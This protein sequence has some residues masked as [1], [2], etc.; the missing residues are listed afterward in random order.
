[1][2]NIETTLIYSVKPGASERTLYDAAVITAIVLLLFGSL[3]LLLPSAAEAQRQATRSLIINP[4]LDELHHQATGEIRGFNTFGGWAGF[5]HFGYSSDNHHLWYQDLGGYVE[6]WRQGNS[7]SLLL[8][9]Q[10]Q[11]IADP[12]NDI[13]F[14]PR[15]I[16]WEEGLLY[17]ARMDPGYLQVGF[18]HRCKH[19]IDNLDRGE[20]R[21]LIFSSFTV[22]YQQPLSVFRDNDL[23]LM[24]AYDN[25]LITWDRRIPRDLEVRT[26]DWNDLQ[27]EFTLQGHWRGDPLGSGPSVD[28]R[29][30]IISLDSRLHINHGASAG[31]HVH[32]SGG[33]FRVS[34]NYEYLHDSGI[35]AVPEGV[36]LVSIGIRANSAFVIR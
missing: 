16:F 17:T 28:T 27:N 24:G 26:P 13:N 15:A 31:W 25:Y 10:I 35:P 1:M 4:L 9:G 33:E 29:I 3:H 30:N 14:N 7:Q 19:D 12:H 22:R 21:S 36:H 23:L 6:L 2:I 8:T 5:G 11:F 34:V 20:E 18:L 32:R